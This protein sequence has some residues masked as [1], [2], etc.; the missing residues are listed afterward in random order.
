MLVALAIAALLAAG[1]LKAVTS[2]TRSQA[3]I[4]AQRLDQSPQEH[5]EK[6]LEM[7]LTNADKFRNVKDGIEL[8]SHYFVDSAG[9]RTSHLGC[10]VSYVIRKAAGESWLVRVQKSQDGREQADL[11]SP[12]IASISI[13]SQS[14]NSSSRPAVRSAALLSSEW[15][16][17]PDTPVVS[18]TAANEVSA[19]TSRPKESLYEFSY[20]I[21]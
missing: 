7:E 10:T 5:L 8:Q 3:F 9:L 11:V 20:R 18:V 15:M 13:G 21:R 6:L 16:G 19:A 12:D 4:E 17:I 14:K 1:T 2:L